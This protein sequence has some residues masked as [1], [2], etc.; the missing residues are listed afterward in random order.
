M[1]KKENKK[2]LILTDSFSIPKLG[3]KHTRD[4]ES[5]MENIGSEALRRLGEGCKEVVEV[6]DLGGT[7][8]ALMGDNIA[9]SFKL[10]AINP[11]HYQKIVETVRG[12]TDSQYDE[13]MGL[14][15]G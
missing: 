3:L 12:L 5:Y 6:E 4:Y 13:L 2:V 9:F 11:L 10:V 8:E 15:H 1:Q 7:V 14:L